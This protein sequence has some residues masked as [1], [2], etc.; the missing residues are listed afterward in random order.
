MSEAGGPLDDSDGDGRIGAAIG[1]YRIAAR[2]GR[3]GMGEVFLAVHPTLDKRVA[4]KV[5]LG[6]S[7]RDPE[8]RRRFFEEARA[9][10][11]LDNPHIV[12]VHDLAEL[13]DGSSYM[14]MDFLEGESLARHLA[15]RGRLPAAEA[16]AIALE[17]L[18]GLAAAHAA[19][20]VHRDLKPANL[21]LTRT[22][23]GPLVKVLDFGIAKVMG[24]PR[25]R[26]TRSGV[27][28]GTPEYM[29]PEQAS[30]S[31]QEVDARADLYAMGI[32]LYEMIAGVPPFQS[33]NWGR[34]LL[35][36]Q[37]Q[38]PAPLDDDGGVSPELSAV[39]MRAL[40]KA[41][42]DRYANAGELAAALV[43]A[44]GGRDAARPVPA[45]DRRTGRRF[46]STPRARWS[47]TA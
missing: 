40:A 25:G 1:G 43:A 8:L 12:G 42:S 33:D 17:A 18:E 35:M 20:I 45:P 21:F 26:A 44:I 29:A 6:E 34:L 13:P 9:A 47:E 19:G 27:I 39:V 3:G 14:A 16:V 15:R 11:A 4:I 24:A 2:I 41:P 38:Q 36:H 37:Q 23:K 46:P 28:L 7:A 31:S 10:A 5:L 32:V 30:G 22:K